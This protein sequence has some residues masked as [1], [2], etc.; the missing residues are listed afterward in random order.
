MKKIVEVFNT[1][2]NRKRNLIISA[3]VL[4]LVGYLIGF[5]GIKLV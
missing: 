4:L 5:V 2:I 1:A 3:I